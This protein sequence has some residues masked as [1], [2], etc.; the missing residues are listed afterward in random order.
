[1]Y[2]GGSQ[3]SLAR[4]SDVPRERFGDSGAASEHGEQG[5]EPKREEDS[6]APCQL[7]PGQYMYGAKLL[8]N[9]RILGS[10]VN[11]GSGPASAEANA[12]DVTGR[13]APS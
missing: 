1:M 8:P 3:T 10:G 7:C 2:L 13:D 11:L 4:E 5:Q 12:T 9:S 6:S